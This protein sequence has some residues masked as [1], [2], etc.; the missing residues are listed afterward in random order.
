MQGE[1]QG[2]NIES[3][4]AAWFAVQTKRYDEQRV[5]QHLDAKSIRAFL[6]L[7][8]SC[9]RRNG[10]RGPARLEPLFPGYL[11][12]AMQSPDVDPAHWHIVR[13][14]PGV[15]RILGAEGM[16]VPVPLEAIETIR[17]RVSALGFVRLG[18]RFIPGARV[19]ISSGP[20]AGLEAIFDRPTSRDGRVRVLLELLGQVGRAEVDEVD[21]DVA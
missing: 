11:F 12:V 2:M 4:G 9:R 20:L 1:S 14:T 8:E 13:W 19:R 3:V 5:I 10:S 7:I 16:A 15:R 17:A 6:P 18:I 21:L